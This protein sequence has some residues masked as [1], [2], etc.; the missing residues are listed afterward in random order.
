MSTSLH[1]LSGRHIVVAGAGMAGLSFAVAL[2]KLWPIDVPPPQL[3]IFERD[4]KQDS[5]GRVG[6]SLSLAGADDTGGLVA[7]RDLGL[8]DEILSYAISGVDK[9]GAFKLWD[10]DWSQILSVRLRPASGLPTAGIRIARKHLRQTL[11]E[12]VADEIQW[13]KACVSAT[14]LESGKM[15]V[16]VAASNG[17][18]ETTV[19]CDLLVVADGAS[20]KIRAALRPDDVLQYA[21][22]VQIAG[23]AHFPEGIPTPLNDNWGQQVSGG[24]GVSCFYSPVDQHKVVWALSFRE[25]TPRQAISAPASEQI[26]RSLLN[27]VLARGH[28]LGQ[29]FRTIVG[30]ATDPKGVFCLPARD[31]KPFHHNMELGPV[32]FIGDSN[33]AVSPFAGYGASLALK[34]GWDLAEK[35]TTATSIADAIRKYDALS[36]PRAAKILKTS[37]SRIRWGHSTGLMFFLWRGF[38]KTLGYL[39]RFT[40]RS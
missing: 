19:E 29:L 12:A 30:S 24:H 23:I 38:M 7:L 10:A 27:E 18:Q 20:S 9:N 22:A 40:G 3:T 8:L 17:S 36:V 32:V 11:L 16:Q 35:L 15:L 34:D 4:V 1:F 33:H 31:K 2:H 6:Y 37:R 25:P 5:E 21:G 28:M 39:L 26:A 14:K 13:G